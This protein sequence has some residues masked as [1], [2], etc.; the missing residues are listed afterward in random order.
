MLFQWTNAIKPDNILCAGAP[1]YTTSALFTIFAPAPQTSG[2]HHWLSALKG[3]PSRV[4]SISLI[5]RDIQDPPP[6][7]YMSLYVYATLLKISALFWDYT[8]SSVKCLYTYA[9]LQVVPNET[10]I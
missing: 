9:Q 5:N 6:E 7:V 10:A 4:L 1:L 2:V 8:A 3:N